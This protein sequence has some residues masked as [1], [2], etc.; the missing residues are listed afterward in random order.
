MSERI[1]LL[2]EMGAQFAHAIA[3]TEASPRTFARRRIGPRSP[4]HVAVVATCFAALLGGTAYAVPATR[5][6]VDSITGSLAGWVGGDDGAAPGRAVEDSDN[7]PSWFRASPGDSRVIAEAGGVGLFV[8]RTET[9][10]SP[11]IQ[12]AIGPGM[13]VE[14]SLE[15]WRQKLDERAVVILQGPAAFGPGDLLDDQGRAPLLGVTTRD[16]ERVEV[17]YVDNGPTLIRDN[18]DGGFVLLVDAWRPLRELIAYDRTGEVRER[19]DLSSYDL[20]YLCEREPQCRSKQR[21]P[22]S[23]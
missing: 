1:Q 2:D 3:E 19:T 18:G 12:F 21:P 4:A 20:S 14:D 13:V 17:R 9:D 15:G 7:A 16:V 23:P 11:A 10:G 6:A 22:A 5:G 8:Q